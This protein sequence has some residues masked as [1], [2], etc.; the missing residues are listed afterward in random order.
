MDDLRNKNHSLKQNFGQY[1]KNTGEDNN[2]FIPILV[3]RFETVTCA[4][5]NRIFGEVD[6]SKLYTKLKYCQ[7]CIHPQLDDNEPRVN[8]S[9]ACMSCIEDLEER[10]NEKERGVVTDSSAKRRKRMPRRKRKQN[11]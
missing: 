6:D 5:S 1:L 10:R 9:A 7:L 8:P 2:D 11:K 4:G 3:E